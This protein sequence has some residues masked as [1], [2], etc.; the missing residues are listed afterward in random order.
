[1]VGARVAEAAGA[2]RVTRD[3]V[4]AL[5]RREAQETQRAAFP[6][7]EGWS[8]GALTIFVPG[9]P[10]NPLNGSHEHWSKRARWAKGWRERA[11]MALMREVG[12]WG[13]NRVRKWP[14]N[15]TTPKRITFTIYGP[16]RF[17][18]DNVR[19]VCKPVR[20]ALK[21]MCVIDDDRESA[22]HTF[23]YAQAKPT[24]SAGAIHGIALR[25][26]LAAPVERADARGGL[27]LW[28]TSR[29]SSQTRT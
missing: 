25:I 13:V 12:Q 18:D 19:A 22:G 16:S 23:L 28:S 26:E 24:R 15:T 8:D 9:R 2:V 17:D 1:M 27:G 21:D 10:R 5:A 7:R 11:Q 4:A 6:V 3:E 20:D 29:A 14:W